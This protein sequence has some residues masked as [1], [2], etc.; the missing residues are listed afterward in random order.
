VKVGVYARSLDQSPASPFSLLDTVKRHGLDGCLFPT[1]LDVSPTLDS[2]EI[3]EV[4]AYADS[5]GLYLDAALGQVNPY[6]FAVRKDVLAA[7][8]G[9]FRAGLERLIVVA[10]QMGCS[11][12]FFTIGALSDRFSRSVPWADQL[13][14]TRAFLLSLRPF[15]LDHGCSLDLKTHEEITSAEVVQMVEAVGSDVLGIG[16]D[17]VNVLVRLEDPLAAARRTA[18][19]VKRVFLSDADLF[20][21][22]TGIERKLR[23]LGDGILNWPGMLAILTAAGATPSFTVELHR[24]QFSMPIFDQSWMASQPTVSPAELAEVIRRTSIS[25]RRLARPGRPPREA[26]QVDVLERLP[27]TLAYLPT[28]R[29]V[30][31]EAPLPRKGEGLGVGAARPEVPA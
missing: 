10:S 17:P 5:L 6:H 12:P 4:G 13:A 18:P 2:G 20:W 11:S 24:G 7:G 15:L 31:G 19:H 16:L 30:Y 22:D 25:E 28:L 3:R 27:A 1:P 8:D 23:P 26:Y 14:A 29:A 21:T 9:D